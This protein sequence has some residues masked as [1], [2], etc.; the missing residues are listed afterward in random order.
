MTEKALNGEG[1]WLTAEI[2]RARK[3]MASIPPS[4][5][6]VFRRRPMPA[7]RGCTCGHPGAGCHC[8]ASNWARPGGG[9]DD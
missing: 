9:S 3:R 2:E 4:A 1:A 8:P 5:R 7:A 6:P